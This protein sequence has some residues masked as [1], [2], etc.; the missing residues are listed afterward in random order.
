[1]SDAMVAAEAAP[2]PAGAI[3]DSTPASFSAPLGSQIPQSDGE[4]PPAP[5]AAKPEAKEAAKPTPAKT[6]DEAL[7]RAIQ[8]TKDKATAPEAKKPEPQAEAKPA[9]PREN[10]RFVADPAKAPVQQQQQPP[11]QV[12]T[13]Y[14]DAPARYDD[15][16]KADWDKVPETVR[17]AAHRAIRELEDGFQ[18][19]KG[20][21]EAHNEVREFAELAKQQGTTL[22]QALTNYVGIEQHLRRDLIGG[23]DAVCQNMGVSLRD[24][25]AHVLG[26]T[27]DQQQSQSDATIRELRNE[28]AGLKQQL[29]GVTQTLEQQQSRAWLGFASDA[30]RFPRFEELRNDMG[31]LINSG[32]VDADSPESLLSEAYAMAERLKP[33]AGKAS[34]TDAAHT[35]IEPQ[36]AQTRPTPPLNPAG[37]KS[38][39]G[40][41]IDTAVSAPPRRKPGDPI[42]SLDE[43]LDRAFRKVRS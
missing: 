26:Q 42:P 20:D 31:K 27:P 24:V 1:M 22:K 35:G 9:Q 25:A 32:L 43:S 14:R 3:V 17:G 37:E 40:A 39:S 34:Q 29:G 33:A 5:D 41:P 10:G 23:L 38:I 19:Y 15:A 2:A 13:A 18:K 28:L 36:P 8:R 12:Q 6:L 4:A 30:T 21:A 7:D 11:Q 16:A